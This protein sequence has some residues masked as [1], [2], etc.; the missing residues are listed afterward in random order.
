MDYQKDLDRVEV[1]W[2]GDFYGGLVDVPVQ[3]YTASDGSISDEQ[4]GQVAECCDVEYEFSG[5]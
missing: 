1:D 4:A 2:R 5:R 3:P